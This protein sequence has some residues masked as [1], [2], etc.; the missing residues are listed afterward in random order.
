[1]V[2]VDDYIGNSIFPAGIQIWNPY[3]KNFKEFMKLYRKAIIKT[4]SR[5]SFSTRNM[6]NIC[7]ATSPFVKAPMSKILYPWM[8][9]TFCPLKQY[10]KRL[11]NFLYNYFSNTWK[12]LYL[13]HSY[14]VYLVQSKNI[15]G[16]QSLSYNGQNII[17]KHLTWV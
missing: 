17:C 13:W 2:V 15:Q 11:T 6:L 7:K 1:M 8:L 5:C 9:R 3:S 4:F 10:Q 12:W 14:I 16:F